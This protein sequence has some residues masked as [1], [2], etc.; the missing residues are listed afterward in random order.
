MRL[1]TIDRAE[2]MNS[3]DFAANRPA[4]RSLARIRGGRRGAGRGH[5]RRGRQGLLR[6]RRPQ[7]LHDELR[8]PPGARVPHALYRRPRLRRHHARPRDR[9]ADH[10]GGQRLRDLGRPRARRGLRHPLLLAQRRVRPSGRELGLPSLA[11][12]AAC[13]LPQIV[14]LGNA[15]EI[16]LSGRRVDAEHALRI[17]LVNR[18][19]PAADLVAET[20]EFARAPG[21]PRAARPTLRQGRDDARLRHAARGRAPPRVTVVPRPRPAPRTSRKAPTPSA[22][23]ARPISRAGRGGVLRCVPPCPRPS[24]NISCP[25]RKTGEKPT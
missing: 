14:G 24:P 9:Q 12:A 1:I 10:R 18:I 6:R 5:H 2:K 23:S 20:M 25:P 11:T 3:L 7:D 13:G 22:R 19:V 16:I 15:M 4:D 17:G 8:R 21:E